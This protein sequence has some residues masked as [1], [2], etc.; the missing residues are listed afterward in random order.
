MQKD[1]RSSHQYLLGEGRRYLLL[2][3]ELAMVALVG[4]VVEMMVAVRHFHY[5]RKKKRNQLIHRLKNHT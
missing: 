1:T 2:A 3:V 5:S 4:V